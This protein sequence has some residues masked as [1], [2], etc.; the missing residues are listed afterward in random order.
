MNHGTEKL[1]G[2]HKYV[3]MLSRVPLKAQHA[4]TI[5]PFQS[6]NQEP[7]VRLNLHIHD[8]ELV[9]HRKCIW[10]Y[11]LDSITCKVAEI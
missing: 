9:A 11:P 1:V 3:L 6:I 8:I 10:Y 5:S 7:G 4:Y 2:K